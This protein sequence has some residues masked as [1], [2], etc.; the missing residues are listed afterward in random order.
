MLPDRT[1][2]FARIADH[3]LYYE[4]WGFDDRGTVLVVPGGPG[5]S[6]DYLRSV[7][8]LAPFGYRVIFYDPLGCGRSE[9][10]R[11]RSDCSF[12]H[13]VDEVDAVRRVLRVAG[14]LHLLGHSYGGRVALEAAVRAPR[15]LASLTLFSPSVRL[16]E[17]RSLL[18]LTRLPPN[19]RA[20]F[21]RKNPR[22]EDMW[23]PRSREGYRRFGEGYEEFARLRVC[24]MK[25]LPVDVV[26]SMQILDPG[27]ATAIA[28]SEAEFYDGAGPEVRARRYERLAVPC[29]LTVGRYDQM[30]PWGVRA[31]HRRIPGSRMIVFARSAHLANWEE[32]ELFLKCLDRFYR[33]VRREPP[34]RARAARSE[35]SPSRAAGSGRRPRPP[36]SRSRGRP[37]RRSAVALT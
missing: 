15:P 19:A 29:L 13:S 7:A 35:A 14:P 2:G 10:P 18:N 6:H 1:S 37:T 17:V 16:P 23:A 5:L 31:L 20:F 30:S 25:V 22:L 28:G 21:A 12:R 34:A 32:R 27:V 26:H 9:R 8:D 3:R 33:S 4:T 24:R 36:R 11:R